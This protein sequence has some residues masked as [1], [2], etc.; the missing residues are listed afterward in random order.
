MK[1]KMILMLC[2][3]WVAGCATRPSDSELERA[4][5][6]TIKV[7]FK[8]RGQATID[9]LS[10]DDAQVLCSKHAGEL[11]KDMSEAIEKAQ[12]ATCAT[13]APESS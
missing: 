7:S 10:Q 13:R 11:Q 1:S 6:E 5:A 8:T 3:I 12:Q 9:R 4:L 2:S